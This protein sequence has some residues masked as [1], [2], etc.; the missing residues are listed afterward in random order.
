MIVHPF[1]DTHARMQ[2]RAQKRR[3]KQDQVADMIRGL[4]APIGHVYSYIVLVTP[5]RMWNI[6]KTAK[7]KLGYET[8]TPHTQTR[9]RQMDETAFLQVFQAANLDILAYYLQDAT[10]DD[11]ECESFVEGKS[12]SDVADA[13]Y[14]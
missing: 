1:P 12:Y 2:T 7:D 13:F 9:V 5:D 11:A 8:C 14:K 4:S 6:V 3:V 10:E